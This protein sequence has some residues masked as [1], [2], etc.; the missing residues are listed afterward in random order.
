MSRA[1]KGA[2]GWD[3]LPSKSVAMTMTLELLDIGEFDLGVPIPSA[4]RFK[5]VPNSLRQ[6]YA[7]QLREVE[8]SK[9]HFAGSRAERTSSSGRCMRACVALK[10]QMHYSL[11]KAFGLWRK[12]RRVCSLVNPPHL[13]AVLLWS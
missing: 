3:W 10:L 7:S 6:A 5:N 13:K 2:T 8:A 12:I 9:A 11:L 1:A 4:S